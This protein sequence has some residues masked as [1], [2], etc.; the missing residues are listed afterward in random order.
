[1]LADLV[2]VGGFLVF[3]SLA[4][5][6]I[7]SLIHWTLYAVRN[8]VVAGSDGLLIGRGSTAKVIPAEA[9]DGEMLQLDRPMAG[10]G[11][12]IGIEYAGEVHEVYVVGLF[13]MMRTPRVFLAEMLEYIVANQTPDVSEEVSAKIEEKK[14][15]RRRRSTK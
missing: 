14:E 13:V 11:V 5:L 8:Y 6:A 15:K 7:F 9:L 12:G 4:G 3:L 10:K 2:H 1:V